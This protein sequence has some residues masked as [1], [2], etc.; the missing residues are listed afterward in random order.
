MCHGD[1]LEGTPG[2]PALSGEGFEAGF[3]T[4]PPR[5]LHDLI[6]DLMP[7]GAR[8]TL[9]PQEVLDVTAYLLAENSFVLPQEALGAAELDQLLRRTP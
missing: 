3:G 5:A 6:R 2:G 4:L 9:T 1:R 7:E 8:G